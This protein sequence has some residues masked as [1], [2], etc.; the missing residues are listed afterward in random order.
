MATLRGVNLGGWFVLEK[1]MKPSLFDGISGPDETVFSI[2]HMDAEK[3]L[4]EHRQTFIQEKDIK[5]LA[6]MGINSVRLPLPWWF[7][8]EKPYY[9][10]IEKIDEVIGWFE[11]YGLSYLLDLH[12][13]PG[14]QNGFDNGGITGKIDWPK[15]PANIDKTVEKLVFLAKRYGHNP[16]LFGFEA[17]NEPHSSIDLAVVQSFY[18]KTYQALRPLTKA[19]IVFHDAF[20][21]QDAS[22]PS[23]F[24]NHGFENVAFDVHLYYCFSPAYASYS[25]AQLQQVVLVDTHAMLQTLSG[26]VRVIVG[27][28]SLGLDEKRFANMDDFQRDTFLR[29]FASAQLH[30]YETVFGWYFWS[31]RIDHPTHRTWN[32]SRL[33][34]AGV[35]PHDYCRRHETL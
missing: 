32:F 23:F 12:T 18:L 1:W 26:F 13:A 15:D 11:K 31:Y 17:L 34:D 35:L 7:L 30:S 28:W 2:E 6:D 21:P 8:G 24:A 22:W 33:T 16:H 19:A 10:S 3:V 27:E 14:C 20:R 9:R 4:T 5:A 29:A 25:L